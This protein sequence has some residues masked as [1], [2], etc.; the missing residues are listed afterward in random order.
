M[1]EFKL[2]VSKCIEAIDNAIGNPEAC[3]LSNAD[4]I[5]DF[6]VDD[7]RKTRKV[8][9]A[10]VC[11]CVSIYCFLSRFADWLVFF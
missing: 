5:T 7:N 4:G 6:W 10:S 1:S 9:R 2:G 8:C 11:A 3:N